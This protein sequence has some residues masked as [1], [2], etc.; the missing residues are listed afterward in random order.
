MCE[1]FRPN[2]RNTLI[3]LFGLNLIILT[4]LI[5]KLLQLHC[6]VLNFEMD[7]HNFLTFALLK[8]SIIYF[9]S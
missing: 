7:F 6:A 4:N 1:I 2:T 9:L 3:F 5:L 8:V